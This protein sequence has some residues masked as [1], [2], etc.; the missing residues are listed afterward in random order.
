MNSTAKKRMRDT[1]YMN[2]HE[3]YG[4]SRPEVVSTLKKENIDVSTFE[5]ARIDEYEEAIASHF[6]KEKLKKMVESNQKPCPI[7]GCEGVKVETRLSGKNRWYCSEGKKRHYNVFRIATI[8]E[9]VAERDH[10]ADPETREK[11]INQTMKE[12]IAL[13][14]EADEQG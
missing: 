14:E 5:V 10:G 3:D 2:M 4:L 12:L 13:L 11:R 8:K 9:N 7:P 1:F 6:K